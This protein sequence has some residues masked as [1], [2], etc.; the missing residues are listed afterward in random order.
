M[1]IHVHV[2][3]ASN[4][5]R[6]LRSREILRLVWEHCDLQILPHLPHFTLYVLKEKLHQWYSCVQLCTKWFITLY[7]CFCSNYLFF[8]VQYRNVK[9]SYW[10]GQRKCLDLCS[11]HAHNV[12]HLSIILQV[13]LIEL[14]V[15]IFFC[16]CFFGLWLNVKYLKQ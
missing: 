2:S 12:Y 7:L 15:Y 13:V 4:I 1:N 10:C 8:H 3:L 5:L 11:V 6:I 9:K 14:W 16:V